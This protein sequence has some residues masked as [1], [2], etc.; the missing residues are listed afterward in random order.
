MAQ[1]LSKGCAGLLVFP[2]VCSCFSTC[3]DISQHWY[4]YKPESQ[5]GQSSG[6]KTSELTSKHDPSFAPMARAY[7][8]RSWC[9][10]TPGLQS[11]RK[12][13]WME[14]KSGKCT[15][16]STYSFTLR[17]SGFQKT[18][19]ASLSSLLYP[20]D[21]WI[22]IPSGLHAIGVVMGHVRY[23]QGTSPSCTHQGRHGKHHMGT[24]HG[25]LAHRI[26]EGMQTGKSSS[27]GPISKGP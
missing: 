13:R 19:S 25:T 26:A 20:P 15:G 10:E 3:V 8:P 2:C 21:Q 4:S 1:G 17:R 11:S 7:S 14:R 18:S 23:G 24:T 16:S 5:N 9:K 22:E 27:I 12:R 6:K